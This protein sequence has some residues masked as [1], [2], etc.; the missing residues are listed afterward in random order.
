[1]RPTPRIRTILLTAAVSLLLAAP[2]TAPA[3]VFEAFGPNS[4]FPDSNLVMPFVAKDSRVGF[5]SISNLGAGDPEGAPVPVDWRF[6]DES[7][8]LLISVE[9]HILGEGG[10][11]IVDVTQVRSKAADGSQGP[12]TNLSGR[13]GFVVVSNENGEPDLVGNYTIANTSANSGF[14]GNAAGLGFVGLLAPNTFLFGTSFAPS[15]LGDNLLMILGI[16]DFDPVPTSLTEGAIPPAG[17]VIFTV[18]VSLYSNDA[19]SGLLARVEVPVQG[20]AVFMSLQE[21]FP[22]FDLNTSVSIV[23]IPLT[24]GVSIIGF[25]GQAVGQFGAGQSLRTDLPF[26]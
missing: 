17:Q 13:N 3:G 26:K 14:G 25:Y 4:D 7:G 15:S 11:D 2:T 5:F 21:L 12:S 10:T 9:R 8:E 23:T 19:P 18:E 1:M 22:G 16:D 24:E 6:Y 20:T